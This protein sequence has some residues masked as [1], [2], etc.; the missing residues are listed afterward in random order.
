MHAFIAMPYGLK[1][2]V[3]FNRVYSSLIK[4]ALEDARFEVFRADEEQ[5]AGGVA[6]GGA[7]EIPQGIAAAAAKLKFQ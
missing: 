6:A 2:G 1:E 3:D 5:R 7:D 4:P